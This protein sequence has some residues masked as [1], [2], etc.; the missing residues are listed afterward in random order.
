[1]DPVVDILVV[2]YNQ[3]KFIKDCILSITNQSYSNLRI[4]VFDDC[5]TDKTVGEI[6]KIKD[7]RIELFTSKK[8]LGITA[9]HNRALSKSKNQ[10]FILIGGDDI[11]YEH[12]VERQLEIMKNND[13]SI[14]GHSLDIID[15]N[16]KLLEQ[17]KIK[18]IEGWGYT[19]WLKGGMIYGAFSIMYNKKFLKSNPKYDARL[20]IVSDWKFVIDI[21][22]EENKYVGIK[23]AL[24]GY[25]KHDTNI[26]NNYELCIEEQIKACDILLYE[27]IINSK[28]HFNAVNY[29]KHYGTVV[30]AIKRKDRTKAREHLKLLFIRSKFSYLSLKA[31]FLYFFWKVHSN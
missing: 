27:K 6:K 24:G 21:L 11:F 8:N 5:S 1:M 26:T 15:K 20:S 19:N 16:G 28:E 17:R 9:N 31:I 30:C 14:C 18:W 23:E 22:G 3:E 7:D 4:M 12:K 2:C 10:F 29:F 25:R 13:I